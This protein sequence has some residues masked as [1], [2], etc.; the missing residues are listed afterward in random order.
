MHSSNKLLSILVRM[1][2]Q[3]TAVIGL[4]GGEGEGKVL[5]IV[6]H[7]SLNANKYYTLVNNLSTNSRF[8][9]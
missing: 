1:G 2:V 3:F 6:A 9:V 4:K 7:T 8:C 5:R